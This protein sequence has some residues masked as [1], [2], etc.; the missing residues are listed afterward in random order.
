MTKRISLR[1][2]PAA[3]SKRED[4][5]ANGTLTGERVNGYSSG[6]GSLPEPFVTQYQ[7]DQGQIAYVVRSYATPI[8]W[9]L[10]DGTVRKPATRYSVTTSKHQSRL[11]T[12]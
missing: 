6:T 5:N 10:T 4:F 11:Y 9:V 3:V 7:N 1:D 12:L 2:V 8:A